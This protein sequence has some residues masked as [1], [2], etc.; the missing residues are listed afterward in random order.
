MAADWQK[1]KTEYITTDSSLRQL[2]Q[3]Y[4]IRYATIHERCKKEEWN[5][6]RDNHRTSTVQKTVSRI[7]NKQA[8]KMSRID[9]ITDKLLDK[10]EQAIDELDLS[11]R[12]RKTKI[13][14][15]DKTE[16]TIE[17][18]EAVED[19]IVDRNGL[20]QITAALK[21]LKE[22]QM[23][24]SELDRREQ[25]ARIEKLHREAE[26]EDRSTTVTVTLEGE[27]DSYGS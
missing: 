7:S 15:D 25:E 10:L 3:K 27:M 1:I 19:G 16:Q 23:I 21:D 20:R 26:K 12:K 6:M 9:G 24:K 18:T 14:L 4:G 2:A 8:D 5:S 11:I 17:W 13:E 22:I